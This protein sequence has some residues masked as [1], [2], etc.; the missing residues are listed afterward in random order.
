MTLKRLM[1]YLPFRITVTRRRKLSEIEIIENRMQE[2][3]KILEEELDKY[4]KI[5]E[6]TRRR[7]I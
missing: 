7:L 4:E 6:E 5:A 3:F 1:K 2:Q